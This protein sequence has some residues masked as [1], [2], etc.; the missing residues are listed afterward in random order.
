[1]PRLFGQIVAMLAC[2]AAGCASTPDVRRT[3]ELVSYRAAAPPVVAGRLSTPARIGLA[4]VSAGAVTPVPGVERARWSGAIHEV[5]RRLMHP[6]ALVPLPPP[7]PPEER[8][9]PAPGGARLAAVLDL[10]A[11]AGLD[12]VLIYE[13]GSRAEN[14]RVAWAITE[15]PLFG[16]VVPVTAATEAHG[17]ALAVLADPR[18]GA[19][20][21]Q[22]S[23]RL[24]DGEIAGLRHTRG[25]GAAVAGL[26]DYALV[27]RLVPRAEDMLIGAVSGGL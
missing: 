9:A 27:H 5:N 7:A 20:I 23:A 1:M 13:V 8:E 26:A 15:L 17:T 6:L 25:D 2:L 18:T 22:A 3:G 21:G 14:D 10:A 11:A 12:A 4:R 16:G 24:S 19:L